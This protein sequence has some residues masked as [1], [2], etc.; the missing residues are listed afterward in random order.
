VANIGCIG[1]E[2]SWINIAKLIVKYSLLSFMP[3]NPI[4]LSDTYFRHHVPILG[5]SRIPVPPR[6]KLCCLLFPRR[7]GVEGVDIPSR[8]NTTVVYISIFVAFF[9]IPK[10]YFMFI[11]IYILIYQYKVI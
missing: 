4:R 10:S 3:F 6:I 1:F 7:D 5:C 9:C 11:C 2:N 8:K